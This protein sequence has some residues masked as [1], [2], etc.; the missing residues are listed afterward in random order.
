MLAV[1][2]QLKA[3][4]ASFDEDLAGGAGKLGLKTIGSKA[5]R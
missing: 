5:K 3:T 2:Q 1:A 4:V